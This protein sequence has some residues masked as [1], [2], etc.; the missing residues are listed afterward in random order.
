MKTNS[1]F[2][3]VPLW[4]VAECMSCGEKFD[5]ETAARHHAEEH[6]NTHAIT[7]D[8]GEGRRVE[9]RRRNIGEFIE[10]K[11]HESFDGAMDSFMDALE[12]EYLDGSL[13]RYEVYG[14]LKDVLD[15]RSISE[16]ARSRWIRFTLD[17]DDRKG[18]ES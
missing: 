17:N 11:F 15:N 12:R 16:T 7:M 13:E 3:P 1:R 5:S 8:P 6:D 10:S 14:I 9:L 18:D 2:D 4:Y